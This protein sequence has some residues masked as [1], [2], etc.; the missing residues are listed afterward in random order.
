MISQLTPFSCGIAC[1]AAFMREQ[2]IETSEEQILRNHRDICFWPP[3]H[4]H[5]YGAVDVSRLIVL[6][7][8]YLWDAKALEDL[9]TEIISEK[10]KEPGSALFLLSVA[11]DGDDGSAHVCRII[12]MKEDSLTLLDP[13]FPYGRIREAF[14]GDIVSKWKPNIVYTFRR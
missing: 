4:S 10:L 5:A 11:H 8:R 7:Q 9:N 13:A 12:G 1:W 6:A 14:F 2:G 3:P